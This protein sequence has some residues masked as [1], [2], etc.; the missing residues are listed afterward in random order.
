MIQETSRKNSTLIVFYLYL[1]SFVALFAFLDMAFILEVGLLVTTVAA[2]LINNKFKMPTSVILF[3]LIL[4]I[5]AL[6]FAPSMSIVRYPLG[7]LANVLLYS[8]VPIYLFSQN[9]IDYESIL[10]KWKKTA[11]VFSL[12]MPLLLVY[13]ELRFIFY[14]EFG[15]VA[16]LNIIIFVLYFFV[17]KD[18]TPLNFFL[19]IY[20]T[21]GLLLWG[22]RLVLLSTAITSVLIILILIKE[23]LHIKIIKIVATI[24]LVGMLYVNLPT[25]L[26]AISDVLGIF[27]I[28]SR[29]I[30]LLMQQVEGGLEAVIGS[31]QEF[32][33]Q[34]FEFMRSSYGV[35]KGFGVIRSMTNGEYYHAHNFIIQFI[36]TFGLVSLLVFLIFIIIYY[37]W[38]GRR[39]YYSDSKRYILFITILSFFLRSI[40]G[41]NFYNDYIFY[42]FVGI[43]FSSNVIENK[44]MQLRQK[45]SQWFNHIKY[46]G[47]N[48]SING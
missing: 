40:A 43:L 47:S 15:Y 29:N 4:V 23:R 1:T 21:I 28:E 38:T 41:T 26:V 34:M 17:K 42:I 14:Y 32:Y 8:F 33:P 2:S 45:F 13:R 12:L 10:E 37:I 9:N 24:F 36:L 35:P 30:T 11:T 46:G 25:I 18:Y 3:Y 27:D 22:S 5:F 48:E 31:R 16:H 20:N 6:F 39:S 7:E 44:N 19:I